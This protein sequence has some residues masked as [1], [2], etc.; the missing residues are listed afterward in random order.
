MR[1][2]VRL[3]I[4]LSILAGVAAPTT[5]AAQRMWVGFHDD[6]S[7]RWSIEPRGARAGGGAEQR[8]DHAAPRP[9]EPRGED[10]PDERRR[11]VRPCVRVRRHRRGRQG[12]TAER[13]RGRPHHLGNAEMGER[14][15]DPERD[16]DAGLRLRRLRSRD[17]VALFGPIRGLPV[18]AVLLD[19][20]RAQPPGFP[21]PAVR[22]ARAVGRAGEL[23][24]TRRD[25]LHRHQGGES[26]CPRRHR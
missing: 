8:D 16:A 14:G 17:R 26:A 22:Q 15:Q 23:R 9:V 24:E 5:F 11:P 21:D 12:G 13:P 19:L 2:I 3:V 6:P 18:R 20:E 4:A 10:T 25:R 1:R 7:F